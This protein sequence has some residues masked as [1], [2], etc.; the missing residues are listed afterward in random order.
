MG[1]DEVLVRYAEACR[2]LA[3]DY[4]K[5]STR[6]DISNI[7]VIDSRPTLRNFQI[8]VE[9]PLEVTSDAE[10]LHGVFRPAAGDFGS[11][12][13]G[14]YEAEVQ[15]QANAEWARSATV[16][17]LVRA[18]HQ[19][20]YAALSART[21]IRANGRR[22]YHT[23]VCNTC[24]GRGRVTCHT[25]SGAG[26]ERCDNCYGRTTC[27]C[28]FCHGAG[29]ISKSVQRRDRDG[30]VRPET[31]RERCGHCNSGQVTCGRCRG[32]GKITC[33]TCSGLG[34]VQCSSCS[35]HGYLTRIIT[36]RVYTAARYFGVYPDGTPDHVHQALGK[37]GFA[38]LL[39]YGEISLA[40]TAPGN[41]VAEFLYDCS[42]LFCE[43]ELEVLGHRAH[44]VFFGNVP[45]IFDTGGVLEILLQDDH[46]NLAALSKHPERRSP[47]FYQ[48]ARKSI[49]SFM[50]SEVHQ[51][52]IDAS[53]AGLTM[54][55]ISEQL[56]RSLSEA[57]VGESLRH[58]YMAVKTATNWSRV[59]W[60]VGF[61]MLSIPV[62]LL[63]TIW[64]EHSSIH[65][66]VGADSHLSLLP[67]PGS[68]AWLSVSPF[69]VPFTFIGW[70]FARSISR[71]WLVQA[72]GRRLAQW[73]SGG[74]LSMGL[75]T[76]LACM[77]SA[78]VCGGAFFSTFPAW[79]DKSGTWCT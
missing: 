62:S 45:H 31:V 59:K 69:A 42:M 1:A 70:F 63:G 15:A 74:K 34:N 61:G 38:K 36:T 55:A 9:Y 39:D 48:T 11:D 78:I 24:H 50:E 77:A 56:H 32:Q 30:H 27:N 17:E 44:W 46:E 12:D 37:A 79:I 8:R 73:A 65:S 71:R 26:T 57:Y 2:T 54:G 18:V 13:P 64:L 19:E 7:K 10:D 43:M 4:I 14:R 6:F 35:G 49:A 47:W 5:R 72:G 53:L 67:G 76:M 41:A 51:R 20:G 75:W 23:Y 16:D 25:C 22:L 68:P 66:M 3:A 29:Y 21:C 40:T 28:S 58:I 33:R 52:M 60:M